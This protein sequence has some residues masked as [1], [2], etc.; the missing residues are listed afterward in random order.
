MKTKLFR[1]V[2]LVVVLASVVNLAVVP[3]S[4]ADPASDQQAVGLIGACKG[5]VGPFAP[6]TPCG[7]YST[8]LT[9]ANKPG[10]TDVCKSVRAFNGIVTPLSAAAL[11]G[12]T[13]TGKA[14]DDCTSAYGI[15]IYFHVKSNK[16]SAADTKTCTDLV[17]QGKLD[18]ANKDPDANKTSCVVQG[19]G[20][21]VCPVM[22]FMALLVDAAYLFV[23]SLLTV[24]P[25]LTT[26]GG[27]N[28]I[29]QAW[30]IMRNFA[31][32]AFVIAFMVIILSQ[33]SSIG[34]TNYGI[35]KLLPK[36]VISAVL[37]NISYWICAIAVDVSNIL[38]TS[39]NG[40]F[41]SLKA[42]LAAPSGTFSGGG[43]AGIV[44]GVLGGTL[45]V[46]A[47]L[48][49][50]LSAL[51]PAL[52]TVLFAIVV[53]FLVLTLRQALIILLIVVAPLA[54]VA[55]LLPN[56]ESLFKKWRELLQ[57]LLLM[58]PIIA[59]IFGASA[60]ASKIVM[61]TAE[62]PYK[63]A[64]Q[65]MGAMIGIIPLA[66]TPIVMR[67]SSGILSR[68]GGI[69]N[70]PNK[71]P[72]DRMKKGAQGYREFKQDDMRGR[73][74]RRANKIL[75]GDGGKLGEQYSRRRR[76]ASFAAGN[77]GATHAVDKERKRKFAKVIADESAD[78]YFAERA[79]PTGQKGFAAS[80]AGG[81]EKMAISVQSA[82]EAAVKKI[83]DGD[84]ASREV[85]LR[86]DVKFVNNPEE[87]L[88]EAIKKGDAVQAVAA[89]NLIYAS[90]SGG[91]S[92]FR[93]VIE[94]DADTP[95]AESDP[96]M[97]AGYAAVEQKLKT[98]VKEKHGQYAKQKGADVVSWANSE[99]G[100]KLADTDYAGKL[101][102]S[103]IAGQHAGSLKKMVDHGQI[104]G[105]QA[106]AVLSDPLLKK[107]LDP[108]KVKQLTRAAGGDLRPNPTPGELDIAHDE[109][110]Q[111]EARRNN[112][113]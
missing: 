33:V 112:N 60:L 58:Y 53:V 107:D 2:A 111:E 6:T 28:S 64:I 12:C 45:A 3:T 65:I 20:W 9:S 109:A 91:I 7:Q 4:F 10:D 113:P 63:I 15:C 19:I 14:A 97:A 23:S 95:G 5:K 17:N 37:V 69:I 101:S 52:I 49:V 13:K 67:T 88:K 72:F 30:S 70:N 71:G 31:N 59:L 32:V 82:A 51:V 43:W 39:I 61:T 50:G 25:L 105:Q 36:L 108:D 57:S 102:P 103:E 84:V 35:K 89:Q 73:R 87:A 94:G 18:D 40:L 34:I 110:S 99:S 74:L 48:Y 16:V 86:A 47:L 83:F 68:F 42:T 77:F 62:G 24:Q 66:L 26:T 76:A 85:L 41:E 93:K 46:G 92:R 100:T 98:N 75:K 80:M 104:T 90:G 8:C 106:R 96:E 22:T 38:G 81:N 11:A 55:Y 56:T 78:Q 27:D 79:G 54:F 21:L 29:Y 44:G 1:I